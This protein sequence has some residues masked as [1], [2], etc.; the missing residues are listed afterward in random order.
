MKSISDSNR[1]IIK[2]GSSLL[3]NKGS[4]INTKF[5]D[6]V[7]ED[8]SSLKKEGIEILIVSS[9]AIELGKV[10]LN[11]TNEKLT[12][13]ESQAAS[14]IGQI[15]LI[16][17]WKSAFEEKNILTAQILIT[18]EDT[19]NRK[20]FLNARTTIEELLKDHF[21]PIINEN[22]T[23]ATSEIKYGD[24]DRLAAR[25]AGMVSAD[26]LLLLSN[27][28]GL[29]EKDPNIEKSEIILEVENIDQKIIDMA[30]T[31][32]PMGK[33]GMKTKIEAAKIAT[34]TG[35]YMIISSGTNK[36]PI[37]SVKKGEVGTWFSPQSK[38]IN[39]LKSW[40]SGSINTTGI[41]HIDEG[42]SEA[43][44]LGNSLLSVGISRCEGNF[45]KGDAVI[46]KYKDNEIARGLTNYNFQDLTKIIGKK[47]EEI[48]EILG[49]LD[50]TEVIHR[51]NLVYSGDNE[52][53]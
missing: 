2:I 37:S 4:G 50:K 41:I 51:N 40:I 43:L 30:G 47:S 46:I 48:E 23:V 45:D 11:K 5:L 12:L 10:E 14:S 49:Y 52:E 13:S 39:A 17:A 38:N 15:K 34:K 29:H 42:A 20:R 53:D 25:I 32:S 31:A 9:G 27:V 28:N 3:I 24:N 8:I 1:V 36:R 21:I 19:E 7:V 26:C 33:G 44:D 6:E 22:D 35:C 16:N 18:A